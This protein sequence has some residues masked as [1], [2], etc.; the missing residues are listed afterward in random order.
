MTSYYSKSWGFCI[1]DSKRKKLDSNKKFHVYIDSKFVDG[2]MSYGEYYVKGKSNKEIFLQPTF[3][4]HLWQT[5][6]C[7]GQLSQQL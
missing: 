2:E 4:T 5:M 1:E 6:N 3:A 7:P